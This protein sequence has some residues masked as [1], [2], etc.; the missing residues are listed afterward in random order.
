MD[1]DDDT[2]QLHLDA[3]GAD[4]MIPHLRQVEFLNKAATGEVVMR[5]VDDS[6]QRFTKMTRD[7]FERFVAFANKVRSNIAAGTEPE[8]T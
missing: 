4:L 3:R 2:N 5:T 8:W 6:G 1:A 7:E